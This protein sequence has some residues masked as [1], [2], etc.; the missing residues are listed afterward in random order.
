MYH[1]SEPC[2]ESAFRLDASE[3]VI[4]GQDLVRQGDREVLVFVNRPGFGG[5]LF[6]PGPLWSGCWFE[7]TGSRCRTRLVSGIRSR[8]GGGRG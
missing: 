2:L 1:F 8:N 6:T 5:G 4:T 7:G 3:V